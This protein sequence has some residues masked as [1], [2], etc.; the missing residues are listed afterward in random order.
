MKKLLILS[1]V[2]LGLCNTSFADL[3]SKIAIDMN[4]VLD[5]VSY[6]VYNVA[7]TTAFPQMYDCDQD[8]SALPTTNKLVIVQ[9]V[10]TPQCTTTGFP[11]EVQITQITNTETNG[12]YICDP[13]IYLSLQD[14]P[15]QTTYIKISGEANGPITCSCSGIACDPNAPGLTTK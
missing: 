1:T 4:N 7:F 14:A 5:F 10:V 2:A 12:L 6:D 3:P 11:A 8:Y 9:P 15:D 13:A